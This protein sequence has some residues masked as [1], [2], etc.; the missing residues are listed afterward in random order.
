[1][2]VLPHRRI[3]WACLP[4]FASLLFIAAAS[5]GPA[6]MARP[7]GAPATSCAFAPHQPRCPRVRRIVALPT[8][9]GA[10]GGV[11]Y[12]PMTARDSAAFA[13]MRSAASL[14]SGI[15]PGFACADRAL[16]PRLQRRPLRQAVG[17]ALNDCRR[18]V[19]VEYQE[20]FAT[21]AR[22]FVANCVFRCIHPSSYGGGGIRATARFRCN[23]RRLYAYRNVAFAY[24]IVKGTGYF[25]SQNKYNNLG[26]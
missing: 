12:A 17:I 26:C 1:V 18:G 2:S 11:A 3:C 19:G 23:T 14:R 8:A 20:V 15:P 10:Q 22:Y 7:T 24:S 16:L 25:S 9:A 21:L 6:R 13:P 4:M 5:A